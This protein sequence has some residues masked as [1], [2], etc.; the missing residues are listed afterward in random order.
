MLAIFNS[1]VV[2]LEYV[3][4]TLTESQNYEIIDTTITFIFIFDVLVAFNTSYIDVTGEDVTDRRKIA[5][6][7]IRG[8]F[9]I[10]LLSSIPYKLISYFIPFFASLTVLKILKIIRIKRIT[11]ALNNFKFTFKEI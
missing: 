2:P 8:D 11:L 6:K 5:R 1:F 3:Y 7:Y 9:P 4:E 10:D